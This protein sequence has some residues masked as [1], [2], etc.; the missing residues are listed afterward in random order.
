MM[1]K[2]PNLDGLGNL[3]EKG[4]D[5]HLTGAQ[6]EELTGVPLPKTRSYLLY[7]SAIARWAKDHGYEITDIIEKPVIER[8]IYFK[9]K[10]R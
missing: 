6:Y 3:I 4:K 5:F 9:K 1:G 10:R 2:H 7:D 8:T